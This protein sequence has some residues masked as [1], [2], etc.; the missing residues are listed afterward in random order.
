MDRY[1]GGLRVGCVAIHTLA[2]RV[3]GNCCRLALCVVQLLPA[4]PII[5][6]IVYCAVARHDERVAG[7]KQPNNSNTALK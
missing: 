2:V 1:T 5:R 3:R 4:Q 6:Y 7:R